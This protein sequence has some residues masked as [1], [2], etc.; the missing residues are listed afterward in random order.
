MG[1]SAMLAIARWD[2]LVQK[3]MNWLAVWKAKLL[4][5]GDKIAL[6]EYVFQ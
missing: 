2:M 1:D 5:M 6:I 4:L 3:F